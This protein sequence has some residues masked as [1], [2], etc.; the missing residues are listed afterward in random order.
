MIPLLKRC[1]ATSHV[2]TDE[3]AVCLMTNAKLPLVAETSAGSHGWI[4]KVFDRVDA[5]KSLGFIDHRVQLAG[6]KKRI[7]QAM[8]HATSDGARQ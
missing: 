7:Q 5:K 6:A 8:A 4:F 1:C 3:P 2:Q